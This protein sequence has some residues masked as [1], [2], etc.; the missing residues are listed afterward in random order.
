MKLSVRVAEA[1]VYENIVDY[2]ISADH[3]FLNGMGVNLKLPKKQDWLK[4]IS[5]NNSGVNL[6][7]PVG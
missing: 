7:S 2:F 4:L 6:F 5:D 1:G 3:H